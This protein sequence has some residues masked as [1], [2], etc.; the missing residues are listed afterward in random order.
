MPRFTGQNKKRRDPRYFLNEILSHETL[1]DDNYDEHSSPEELQQEIQD[2][3][4][5]LTKEQKIPT[6]SDE[7]KNRV[8]MFVE[9]N[10]EHYEQNGEFSPYIAKEMAASVA[11]KV[12]DLIVADDEE[13]LDLPPIEQDFLNEGD[14]ID[15]QKY[16]DRVNKTDDPK[17]DPEFQFPDKFDWVDIPEFQ[18]PDKFDWVDNEADL[19]RHA[20]KTEEETSFSFPGHANAAGLGIGAQNSTSFL[21]FEGEKEIWVQRLDSTVDNH[22]P[23]YYI[24]AWP[25]AERYHAPELHFNSRFDSSERAKEFAT[26]R[27]ITLPD[28]SETQIDEQIV[29]IFNRFTGQNKK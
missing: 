10:L 11:R 21:G 15:F 7:E 1:E 13:S 6:L 27:G 18:F 4:D 5:K 23:G 2:V 8:I 26:A 24:T 17:K 19:V 9:K 3:I 28:N 16:K 12:A 14:V 25:N 29:K 22:R 20:M